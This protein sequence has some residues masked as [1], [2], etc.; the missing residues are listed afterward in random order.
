MNA[1]QKRAWL[2]VVTATLCILLYI[3]FYLIFGPKGAFSAFAIF[4]VNGFAGFIGRGEQADER[5]NNIARQATSAGA[6]MSYLAFVL[7]C[8]GT[9][10][11]VYAF[12]QQ[13][14]VRVHILPMITISC[15]IIF[16]FTRSVAILWLY[17]RHVEASNG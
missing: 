15:G 16:Y 3:I 14:Q 8:M 17:G 4:G 11:V 5:D 2:A 1:E 9:W 13:E 7:G 12:Q 10:V 6:I